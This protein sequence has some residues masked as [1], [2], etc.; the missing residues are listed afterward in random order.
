MAIT[1]ETDVQYARPKREQ[2]ARPNH[3][4]PKTIPIVVIGAG[5]AG[6]VAAAEAA[7]RLRHVVARQDAADP[8]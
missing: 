4:P 7:L 6:M 3:S 2:D 1:S 8:R 5:A